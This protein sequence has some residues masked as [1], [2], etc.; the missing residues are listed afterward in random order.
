MYT[1]KEAQIH[2]K[3]VNYFVASTHTLILSTKIFV[4][5][6]AQTKRAQYISLDT[7][8]GEVSYMHTP[9]EQSWWQGLR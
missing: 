8:R 6:A 3:L 9:Q 4:A 7:Q 5:E 1:N 2:T